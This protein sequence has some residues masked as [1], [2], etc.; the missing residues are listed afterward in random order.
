MVRVTSW[1]V[2]ND[3]HNRLSDKTQ[4]GGHGRG[5]GRGH[6]RRA[7]KAH[8]ASPASWIR[9]ARAIQ[10]PPALLHCGVHGGG[11]E[12]P[13]VTRRAVFAHVRLVFVQHVSACKIIWF[14]GVKSVSKFVLDFSATS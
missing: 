5:R 9:V 3:P 11:V 4:P 2:T 7:R 12:D 13:P 6:C 8:I 10:P 1:G 14:S